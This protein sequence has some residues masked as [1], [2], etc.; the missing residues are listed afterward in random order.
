MGG[1]FREGWRPGGGGRERERIRRRG[2]A[3]GGCSWPNRAGKTWRAQQVFAYIFRLLLLFTSLPLV[4][5]PVCEALMHEWVYLF[6]GRTR[7]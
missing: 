5:T 4:L 3:G 6:N 2:K 7:E 1:C